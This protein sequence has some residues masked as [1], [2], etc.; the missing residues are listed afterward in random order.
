MKKLVAIALIGSLF[1]VPAMAQPASGTL[2]ALLGPQGAV[3][4]LVATLTN[5]PNFAPLINGAAGTD[6]NGM[7]SGTVR[8]NAADPLSF[9]LTSLLVNQDPAGV[10]EGLQ[11]TV[12]T[13]VS[14]LQNGLV[15]SFGPA[16]L[17]G[18]AP[19]GAGL[20]GLDGLPGLGSLPGLDGLP[21][22]PGL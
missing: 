9:T 14:A 3:Q 8:G 19:T 11:A 10:A 17:A 12:V 21:T 1:S 22:L 2:G 7:Q 6:A 18:L 13:L 16:Q 4:G 15:G 20:P 5:L